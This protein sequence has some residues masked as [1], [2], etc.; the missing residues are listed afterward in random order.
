MLPGHTSTVEA[1][2]FQNG[3]AIKWLQRYNIAG[4]LRKEEE[5]ADT[6]D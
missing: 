4:Y 1:Q 5:A 2:V 6:Y 3:R